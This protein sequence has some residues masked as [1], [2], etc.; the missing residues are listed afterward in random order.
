MENVRIIIADDHQM[1]I[2]GIKALLRKEKHFQFIGE[3]QNGADA[4]EFALKND[5]E[6]LITDIS[7][8]KMNGIELT[9]TI[10]AHNPEIKILVLSMY[11][12]I[13]IVHQIISA[14]ADG[15]ILKNTG[16]QELMEAIGH[17][18]NGGSFYSK[19]VVNILS[20]KQPKKIVSNEDELE[21]TPRELEIIKLIC[22][23]NSN[24]QIAE[25]LFISQRTVETHRKN[26]N[27]KT[28]T[29]TA[30]G[31]IKFAYNHGLVN[32]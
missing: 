30:L 25:Q 27:A 29:H 32:L 17:I 11:N 13:E 16:K 31:L 18:M 8:P 9:Q 1:F 2:D 22:E 28:K 4:L 19:E 6:L 7:M 20:A 23:E 12:D 3:F 10:K 26:I 15:Y 5:F 21:L 24:H 14:E